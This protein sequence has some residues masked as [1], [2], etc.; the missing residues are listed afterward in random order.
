M[1]KGYDNPHTEEFEHYH[2]QLPEYSHPSDIFGIHHVGW[3]DIDWNLGIYIYIFLFLGFAALM[4][5]KIV[6][7]ASYAQL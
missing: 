2:M 7:K 3:K 4:L 6:N 5:N 1:E